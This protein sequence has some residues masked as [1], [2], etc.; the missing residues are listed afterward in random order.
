[1]SL[2]DRTDLFLE[3]FYRR[4]FLCMAVYFCEKMLKTVKIYGIIISLI[5][6]Q[7][8]RSNAF[9]FLASCFLFLASKRGGMIYGKCERLKHDS[10]KYN[11][12]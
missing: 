3:Y 5:F 2:Q 11:R 10:K 8:R 9:C 12:L 1:M 7:N 6:M 4:A